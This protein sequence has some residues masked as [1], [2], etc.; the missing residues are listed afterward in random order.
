MI[1]YPVTT[2][3]AYAQHGSVSYGAISALRLKS[4]L[5]GAHPETN[6]VPR[7]R[8]ALME[9]PGICAFDL[10]VELNISYETLNQRSLT[11]LGQK[12]PQ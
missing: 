12:L 6:E 10:A 1:S 8:Q 11:L 7:I 3:E 2:L 9:M 5:L 4:I